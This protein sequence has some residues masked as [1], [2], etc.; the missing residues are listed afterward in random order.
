MILDFILL[1]D[2][3]E[4]GEFG[5]INIIGGGITFVELPQAPGAVQSISLVARVVVQPDDRG[6][7]HTVQVRVKGPSDADVLFE[8]PESNVPV[9]LVDPPR[10]EDEVAGIAFVGTLSET[11]FPTFGPY[12]FGFYVDGD[13][14][15]FRTL[16]VRQSPDAPPSGTEPTAP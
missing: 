4:L 2:S 6:K 14:L 8:S 12:D 10:R 7:R 9:E 1:A 3:A 11:V 15:A 5:K 13:L 16:D